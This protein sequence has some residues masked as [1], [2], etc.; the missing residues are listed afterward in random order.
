MK[1]LMFALCVG[2]M[3]IAANAD[4]N[5][6]WWVGDDKT[7][8]ELKGCQMG[9]ASECKKMEGAQVSLLWGR[10]QKVVGCQFA[11]GY[12]NTEKLMNGPQLAVVNV[13]REGAAL[14]F[15]LL[16]FNKSGFLPFFPFFNFST[17]CF[18]NPNK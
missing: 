8:K 18:G 16:N 11:F 6:S 10:T 17:K 14:Q 13:A 3:A 2:L 4:F 1:K 7:D 5:W 12:C 9:I 15:G